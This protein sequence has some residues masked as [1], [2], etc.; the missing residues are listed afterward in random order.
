MGS[1]QTKCSCGE[2]NT[3]EI[4]LTDKH[5]PCFNEL[6]VSEEEATKI[7]RRY[8][9]E[10]AFNM[11]NNGKSKIKEATNHGGWSTQGNGEYKTYMCHKCY[12]DNEDIRESKDYSM[13]VNISHKG[14]W[15]T[16]LP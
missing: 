6:D 13:V 7:K 8:T 5:S 12:L 3:V 11:F 15:R 14:Y 4:V 1:T 2:F 10:N 16:D 9:L